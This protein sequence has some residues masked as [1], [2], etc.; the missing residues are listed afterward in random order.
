VNRRLSSLLKKW[1]A[2]GSQ[3]QESFDW[4]SSKQNW[5]D[6]F[7][8]H[9]TFIAGL[10]SPI[11]RKEVRKICQGAKHSITEKFLA[12]MVWGYGDRGYGP[13]R[14]TKMLSQPHAEN[15]LQT[16]FDLC[17]DSKPKEA[18]L[19]LMQNR[20]KNLGPS[21]GTKFLS[22]CTPKKVGAPILDSFVGMWLKDFAAKDFDGVGLNYQNW[23]FKTY[24]Q[25]WDWV[26]EHADSFSCSPDD[27]ELVLFRDAE[28]FYS[29]SSKWA[30]K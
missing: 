16:V 13:Y 24:S 4:S 3:P 22:F 15:V 14:V 18:Y 23:N 27:V 1:Q 20:I 10:P 12:V 26:K 30:S 28:K 6:A 8:T 2:Q 17:R 29:S 21:F 7:P 11:G 19:C 5:I 25:Y 9:K